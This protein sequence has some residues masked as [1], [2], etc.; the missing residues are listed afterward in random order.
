MYLLQLL[1]SLLFWIAIIYNSLQIGQ[2]QDHIKKL[3]KELYSKKNYFL[4][5]NILKWLSLNF[6]Y[7]MMKS[8]IY[9]HYSWFDKIKNKIHK[10]CYKKY[11]SNCF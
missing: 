4:F 1:P 6:I 3:E 7:M 9:I 8:N 2:L 11:W 10:I 5:I